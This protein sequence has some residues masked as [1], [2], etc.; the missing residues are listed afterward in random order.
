MTTWP[1][2]E[3]LGWFTDW[4]ALYTLRALAGRLGKQELSQPQ[5]HALNSV[6]LMKKSAHLSCSLP[7]CRS[8]DLYMET[9]TIL[10][11][12]LHKHTS[13]QTHMAQQPEL[14]RFFSGWNEDV[15]EGELL[16]ASVSSSETDH[17]YHCVW[18]VCIKQQSKAF[19]SVQIS[20]WNSSL[21]QAFVMTCWTFPSLIFVTGDMLCVCPY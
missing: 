8:T 15:Q 21:L 1:T 9:H 2:A 4:C 3:S 12:T 16:P 20:A 19:A 7:T 10:S 6:K 11:Y 18:R 14:L 13:S 17:V 5:Q